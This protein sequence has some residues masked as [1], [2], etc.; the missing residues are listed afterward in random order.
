MIKGIVFDLDGTLLDS[1]DVWRKVDDHFLEKRGIPVPDDY[2]EAMLT[3]HFIEAAKYTIQRFKLDENKEDIV[4]EWM[5]DAAVMYENEVQLKFG[6]QQLIEILK[7]K[8]YKL[9]IVTS[10]HPNLY[11]PCLKRHGLLDYFDIIIEADTLNLSKSNPKIYDYLLDKMQLHAD[12]CIF[13]DDVY[14]ALK[15]AYSIGI[16]VVAIKDKR[17]YDPR[18]STICNYII[19][20]FTK[21]EG[22]IID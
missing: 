15:A 8:K 21:I 22:L 5:H 13:F 20:D 9:A 10:C 19:E 12:E 18:V 1:M 16:N 2:Q 11:R 4:Q 6:A 7:Q 14:P 3:M 17:S